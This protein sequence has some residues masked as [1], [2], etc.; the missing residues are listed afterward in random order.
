MEQAGVTGEWTMKDTVAHLTTWWRRGVA[1]L[2]AVQRG[3]QPPEHPPQSEVAVINQW[4]YITNRDRP[5]A[6]ILRDAADTWE[7][8]GHSCR[9]SLR[10]HSNV[11]GRR[12]APLAPRCSMTL[13]RISMKSM[14]HSSEPGLHAGLSGRLTNDYAFPTPLASAG[15]ALVSLPGRGCRGNARS[16]GRG[17]RRWRRGVLLVHPILT[18]P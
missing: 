4:E 14:S 9:H 17:W 18:Y 11:R 8:F 3:E 15:G 16:A 10:Q 12:I 1:C 13:R 7:Q 6:D 5:L 2:A